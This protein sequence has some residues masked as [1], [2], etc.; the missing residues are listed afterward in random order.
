M[1]ETGAGLEADSLLMIFTLA[2]LPQEDQH[3]ML[4]NAFKAGTLSWWLH[5]LPCMP[6][7]VSAG[8]M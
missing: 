7:A 8:I 5:L 4:S 6:Q 2:T 3:N 1:C